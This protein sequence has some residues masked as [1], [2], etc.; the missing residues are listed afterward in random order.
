MSYPELRKELIKK[1]GISPQALSQ[2][3][4]KIITSIPMKPR[5]AICIIAQQNGLRLDKYLDEET[6]NRI[7]L[8]L[9]QFNKTSPLIPPQKVNIP[10]TKIKYIKVGK[11]F[12]YTDHLLSQTKITEAHEMSNVFPYLYLL[13]NSI[14][15]FIHRVMNTG[16]GVDWWDKEV[17][18]DLKNK[19]NDRMAK[20][21]KDAWHQRRGD[22]PIDYLDFIELQAFLGK[23]EKFVVPD[24]I[25]DLDWFRQLIKEVY[26]SRCVVC[27]MNPLDKNNISAVLV[28]FNEWQKQINAKKDLILNLK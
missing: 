6:I 22:R 9:A 24:I 25:P 18:T 19:V 1:L 8:L 4:K 23:I 20:D 13:E 12:N 27:H 10:S 3:S 16:Y 28:K 17:K 14:R 26:K 21:K 5:D 2:R 7:R 15:E 11:D